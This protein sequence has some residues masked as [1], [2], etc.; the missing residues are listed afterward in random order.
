MAKKKLVTMPRIIAA[1]V[2]VVLIVLNVLLLTA[3]AC[4]TYKGSM[5]QG[6][7]TV[8]YTAEF[9]G[10]NKLV[11]SVLGNNEV[12][13]EYDKEGK[14]ITVIGAPVLKRNSVFSMQTAVSD[15][16]VTSI[17]PI[18]FQ[19]LIGVGYLAGIY[20][21]VTGGKIKKRR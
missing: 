16:T 13:Y 7:I 19:V 11:Y 10:D 5:K 1:A 21:L 14:A 2:V 8:E 6:S 20:V 4:G 15:T 9:K 17:L 12:T 3:P 18:V